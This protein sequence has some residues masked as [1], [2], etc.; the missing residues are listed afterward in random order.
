[1]PGFWFDRLIAGSVCEVRLGRTGSCESPGGE[2]VSHNSC[3][4]FT[5]SFCKVGMLKRFNPTFSPD[6]RSHSYWKGGY[7]TV[8]GASSL[9]LIPT[10]PQKSENMKK[11][12]IIVG[13]FIFDFFLLQVNKVEILI[14][15]RLAS[16]SFTAAL[17]N[18][19][20]FSQ[21]PDCPGYSSWL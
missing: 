5:S 8:S 9:P 3:L 17:L 12:S 4:Y 7:N 15:N 13:F 2:P 18:A 16:E 1:M 14:L 19:L 6:K 11:I 21:R 20:A 10:H